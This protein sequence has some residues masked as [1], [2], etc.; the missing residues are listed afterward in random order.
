[1]S[2]V[3]GNEK[4]GKQK[5]KQKIEF[6]GDKILL[7]CK[8]FSRKTWKNMFLKYTILFSPNNCHLHKNKN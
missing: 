6:F 8:L 2:L 5:Q 7:F 3:Y 1:M 4:W